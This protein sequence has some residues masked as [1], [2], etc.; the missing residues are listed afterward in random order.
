MFNTSNQHVGETID[1]YVTDLK[2]K[3]RSCEFGVLTDSLIKDRI[4]CGII[5]DRTRSRLLREPDLSLQKALDICR[6]NEATTTQMKLLTATSG[7]KF[8][9]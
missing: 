6:A 7:A 3:V 8:R 1:Q 9:T 2:T 4:V 5:D